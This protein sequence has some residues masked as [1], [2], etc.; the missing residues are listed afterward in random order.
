MSLVEAF[1]SFEILSFIFLKEFYDSGNSPTNIMRNR[2]SYGF[3]LISLI[4]FSLIPSIESRRGGGG[5]IGGSR[6]GGSRGSSGGFGSRGSSGA[7][8]SSGGGWFGGGSKTN[9]GAGRNDY[10]RGTNLGNTRQQASGGGWNSG[11]SSGNWNNN[12]AGTGMSSG[13]WST[14][15]VGSHSRGNTFKNMIVGAAAG[16]LTYQAG[17]A[18]IRAAAGPMMWNNR[19]YYWGSNY[20]RQSPGHTNMCR[21]PIE[22]G[23]PQFGNIYFQ[24]NSRPREITWGCGYYEYCC[25]YECCRGGGSMGSDRIGGRGSS[26]GLLVLIAI[27]FCCG[28]P[29]LT[30][31]I[32]RRQFGAAA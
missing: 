26:I 12:R 4:L 16:Y 7:R 3:F 24:D 20:Y 8:T 32:R 15:G 19:P 1:F 11:G 23:D 18:I 25:G 5:G 10:S 29:L 27:G 14:S 30:R 17:K 22:S 6:G 31:W 13:R 21:M 9:T 2:K 28:F